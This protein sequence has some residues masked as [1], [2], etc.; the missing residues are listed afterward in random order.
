VS[1]RKVT[2]TERF[3]LGELQ[4]GRTAI[5]GGGSTGLARGT[6][7]VSTRVAN[8]LRRRGFVT[9]GGRG[10]AAHRIRLSISGRKYLEAESGGSR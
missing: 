2:K 4:D 7:Y 8:S 3:V 9:S 10:R 1:E 6:L 5:L